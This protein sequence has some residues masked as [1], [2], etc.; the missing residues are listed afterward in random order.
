MK[1]LTIAMLVE[2]G[3]GP[4]NY[5]LH[6]GSGGDTVNLTY[7]WSVSMTDTPIFYMYRKMDNSQ[8]LARAFNHA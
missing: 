7:S 2:S 8:E 3:V 4:S 6:G 5:Q 1:R